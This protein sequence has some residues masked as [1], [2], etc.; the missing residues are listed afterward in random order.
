MSYVDT[1]FSRI[2][3]IAAVI[4][5]STL[6]G[7]PL[8]HSVHAQDAGEDVRTVGD[9]P[10]PEYESVVSAMQAIVGILQ[11]VTRRHAAQPVSD[12]LENITGRLTEAADVSYGGFRGPD[13]LDHDLLQLLKDVERDLRGIAAS[14]ERQGDD[15]LAARLDDVVR[16]MHVAIRHLENE[17]E[18]LAHARTGRWYDPGWYG[19]S[20][21]RTKHDGWDR[22]WDDTDDEGRGDRGDD[23]RWKRDWDEWNGWNWDWDWGCC[24]GTNHWI[25]GFTGRWPYHDR[26]LYRTIPP[27][28]YNRVEGLF[29]GVAHDPLEWSDYDRGRIY[30]QV[31]YAF[32][33]EDWRYE[34]GAE[35]R[36]TGG[37]PSNVFDVKIG[38]AYHLNTGTKDLWKSSWAENTLAAGLFRHD[39]FD[40]Y[41]TEGWTA[42][43]V[44]RL[45]PYVQFSA[46]Y[47]EDEYDTLERSVTWSLFGG[48]P[49][50]TNPAIRDGRMHSLVFALEGGRVRSMRY[51]PIGA[52]FRLEAEVGQGLGGEFDFSRY[53]GDVRTYTR[54]SDYAGL[55]LRFRGGFTEGDV[56]VQKAF[57]IGGIGSVRSYDQN[58]FIGTRM[59]LANA[60]LE[61]YDPDIADWLFDDVTLFGLFDAGWTNTAAGRNDVR[62]DDVIPAAGFGIALD[63]RHIRFELA[64][65]LRDLGTGREPTLWLRLNPTF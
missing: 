50:R 62:M 56:P 55:N 41:Q 46:G 31:G 52:A 30:G 60:E 8:V 22:D 29:I 24:D 10:P 12:Q 20:D 51:R 58:I 13:P 34:I 61:L 47:R 42:Y 14:L 64:W 5:F 37:R 63:D 19:R 21:D 49:F 44:S 4:A 9:E 16:E 57:T 11:N 65:P 2:R 53:S 18:V 40:Y 54:I 23:D 7:P 26:A 6:L 17:D 48:D 36:L 59:L 27:V 32:G 3:L 25:G 28:R 45:T 15:D 43:L 38:G 33:L 35:T 39:F 1:A